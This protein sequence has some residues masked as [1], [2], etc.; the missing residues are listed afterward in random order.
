MILKK[1][2]ISFFAVLNI[3]AVLYSNRPGFVTSVQDKLLNSCFSQL[4]A[5]NIRYVEWFISDKLAWYAYLVGIGNR[6][7]M[8]GFQN[9]FNWWYQIKAKYA[10]SE[11]VL[12]P[13]PRQSK[14]TFWQWLLFDLKEA[15]ILHNMY[16]SE[17]ARQSYSYYLCRRFSLYNN[18]SIDSILWE[19]HWQN[20][21]EPKYARE[22]GTYLDPKEYSQVLNEFKCPKSENK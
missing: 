6:W 12:L 20:I 3:S 11:T 9:H 8:F 10:D 13:L 22:R 5:Y 18:S 7:I 2:L 17:G 21:L 1:L 4:A 14:R 16:P 15:K 19:L